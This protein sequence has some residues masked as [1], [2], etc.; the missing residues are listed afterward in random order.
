M[1]TRVKR[2]WT[3]F[4][5]SP[6]FLLAKRGRRAHHIVKSTLYD[7]WVFRKK[8]TFSMLVMN[9]GLLLN[10]FSVILI[11]PK[12]ELKSRFSHLWAL[13]AFYAVEGGLPELNV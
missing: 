10:L 7:I 4:A 8:A 5:P 12:F 11:R 13:D 3:R 9:A 1:C 6:P 2:V